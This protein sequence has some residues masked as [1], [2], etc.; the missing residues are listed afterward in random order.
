VTAAC[1]ERWSAWAPG[2]EDAD[3]WRSWC[4]DP[5]ALEAG[6]CPDARFL[7]PML[8]RRCSPLARIALTTAFACCDGRDLDLCSTVFASRHGNINESIDLLDRL[9]LRQ[10][11]SPTV[12]SHSVHNAQAALYSLAANNGHGSTSVAAQAD[13][14][15]CAWLEALTL[16]EREPERPVL[17]VM[18]DVPL[19]PAFA[20]LVVEPVASYGLALL[21]AGP[22]ADEG[23]AFAVEAA[24]QPARPARWPDAVEFLRW[25]LSPERRLSLGAGPRRFVWQKCD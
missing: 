12:F 19:A 22:S 8:R 2:R 1:V 5:I 7:P 25:L 20:H 15:G 6:G 14:F 23:I 17:L 4:A 18:A 21:L 24:T 13:T 11:L 9:A 10:P 16:R 3:A